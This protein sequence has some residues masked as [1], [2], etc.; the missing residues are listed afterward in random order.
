MAVYKP[1]FMP[2]KFFKSPKYFTSM[3]SFVDL[4]SDKN[5]TALLFSYRP[6]AFFEVSKKSKYFH[7]FSRYKMQYFIP[8]T[9]KVFNTLKV[10]IEENNEVSVLDV[11][12]SSSEFDEE[13]IEMFNNFSV[14][15][16]KLKKMIN[17]HAI[18]L[19]GASLRLRSIDIEIYANGTFTSDGQNNDKKEVREVIKAMQRSLND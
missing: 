9:K 14:N 16:K 3:R 15:E 4:V 18:D 5:G 6:E 8:T 17:N 13:V 7:E 19:K 2:R 11:D 12:I 1:I 10:L